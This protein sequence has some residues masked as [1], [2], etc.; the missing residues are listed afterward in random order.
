[1]DNV[2]LVGVADI[3][4]SRAEDVAARFGTRLR[5]SFAAPSGG[6]PYDSAGPEFL[7]MIK[8]AVSPASGW[9]GTWHLLKPVTFMAT[10]RK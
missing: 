8:L 5:I 10:E 9:V 3:D 6:R 7:F 2:R 4:R 1:M